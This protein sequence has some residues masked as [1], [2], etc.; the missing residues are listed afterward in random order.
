MSMILTQQ[1]YIAQW[2]LLL[3]NYVN[4]TL[5][6]I[7]GR[8]SLTGIEVEWKERLGYLKLFLE[9]KDVCDVKSDLEKGIVPDDTLNKTEKIYAEIA[10]LGQRARKMV[11]LY[12]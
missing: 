4:S 3:T 10:F 7:G 5:G 1:E 9:G 12:C 11:F 2:Y 6:I 8:M